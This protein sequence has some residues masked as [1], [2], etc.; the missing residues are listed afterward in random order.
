MLPHIRLLIRKILEDANQWS[1]QGMGMFRLYLSEQVRLHVWDTRFTVPNVSTIHTHPWDFES[2]VI[3]GKIENKI[4]VQV[5]GEN[6]HMRQKLLC[7]TGGGLVESPIECRLWMGDSREYRSSDRYYERADIIHESVPED[8][9]ITLVTRFFQEDKDHAY[10]FWPTGQE[11]VSAE[12][13]PA[14]TEEIKEMKSLALHRLKE[15][16]DQIQDHM[17]IPG[18]SFHFAGPH[19]AGLRKETK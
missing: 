15:L 16:D 10:V 14:T 2:L 9:T 6:T 4:Y 1:L 5:D 12:P 8:G 18:A 11:W 19:R 7:G 13:R 3:C 17:K